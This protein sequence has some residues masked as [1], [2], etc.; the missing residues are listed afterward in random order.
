VD[1]IDEDVEVDPDWL[2]RLVAGFPGADEMAWVTGN[3]RAAELETPAQVLI[4]ELGDFS[5]GRERRRYCERLPGLAPPQYPDAARR[6]GSGAN[7]AVRTDG[8]RRR[9]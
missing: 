4:E 3:V 9:G 5:K 7:L 8:L 6:F 2:G 1:F